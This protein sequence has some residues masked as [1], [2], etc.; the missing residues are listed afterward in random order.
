MGNLAVSRASL[1]S[2]RIP[3]RITRWG[4]VRATVGHAYKKTAGVPCACH[5][6]PARK[7]SADRRGRP[8]ARR[9]PQLAIA[10]IAESLDLSLALLDAPL[11]RRLRQFLL[12]RRQNLPDVGVGVGFTDHLIRFE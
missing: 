3:R 1:S 5:G 9:L 8:Q 6:T 7:G 4:C 12:L 11:G 10:T 2:S